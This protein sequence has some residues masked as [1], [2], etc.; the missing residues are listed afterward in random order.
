MSTTVIKSDNYTVWENGLTLSPPYQQNA[1][2][3]D[4]HVRPQLQTDIFDVTVASGDNVKGPSKIILEE[5]E[6]ILGIGLYIDT[7]LTNLESI[8]LYLGAVDVPVS[9]ASYVLDTNPLFSYTA[10]ANEL[11]SWFNPGHTD[12]LHTMLTGRK[13]LYLVSPTT[14]GALTYKVYITILK[15]IH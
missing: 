11:N 6:I 15:V 13:R 8:S 4:T 1:N 12:Y 9:P 14:S 7:G 5:K 2:F 10:S 3:T